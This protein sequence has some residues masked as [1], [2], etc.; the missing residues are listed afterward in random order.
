MSLIRKLKTSSTLLKRQEFY[1]LISP[2][3]LFGDHARGSDRSLHGQAAVDWLLT[4]HEV[5]RGQGFSKLYSLHSDWFGPYAETTGYIIPTMYAFAERYQHRKGEVRA[6]ASASALW[7]RKT[8]YPD[9]AFGD[10]VSYD[11]LHFKTSQ[12]MVFDTGQAIFGMLAAYRYESDEEYL[13]AA[14]RAGDWLGTVQEK[15]GYWLRYAYN[16]M[17]HSYYSRVSWGLAELWAVTKEQ[18]Y[19]DIAE[20]QLR[21][22]VDQQQPSG[23]FAHCSFLKDDSAVLHVIAYTIEG[24]L[25]AGIV[26][27]EEDYINA[28][29]KAASALTK[30]QERD[31][32]LFGHYDMNWNP[33]SKPRCLT[34]LAQMAEIW[35]IL[36]GIRKDVRYRDHAVR[37]L[38]FLRSKQILDRNQLNLY[39]GLIGSHPWW[40]PYFP[41]AVPNWSLKFY[42][43]ALILEEEVSTEHLPSP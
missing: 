32:V 41:W 33:T 37:A 8:Q 27:R 3:I 12:Q 18:K 13:T 17:M 34:G 2:R 9:G 35:L 1:Y 16:E 23:A 29:E 42:L 26:F 15:E 21:W 31:G 30:I 25:K 36:Y 19:R 5:C 4:S 11:P 14:R 40:G 7:L 6:S 20:R 39:G 24:L 38:N 28:A 43:D 22:A 10:S